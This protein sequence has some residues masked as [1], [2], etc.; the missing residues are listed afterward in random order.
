MTA[1][2]PALRLNRMHHPVTVLGPGTRAGI[3]VQGCTIGCSGCAARD[4]WDPAGGEPVQPAEI[5]NWLAALPGPLDGVTITGGEPF[6]QPAALAALLDALAA[7]RGD[8]ELDLLVFS[9]YGWPRL[10]AGEP[11][12]AALA[13]CDAVVAGPYVDRRNTGVPLRGSDNQQVVPLTELGRVRYGDL[14]ALARRR[15]QVAVD[16]EHIRLIGIPGHG[17]LDRM[18]AALAARGIAVE[19]V[20]WQS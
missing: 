6:Q 7:W 15:L 3:W 17:D 12:A 8:R 18:R 9:G 5:V 13:R 4:T 10:A 2:A 16:G 11:Y 20:T 1:E 14:D 19:G